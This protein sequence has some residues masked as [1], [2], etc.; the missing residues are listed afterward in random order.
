MEVTLVALDTA[1]PKILAPCSLACPVSDWTLW[2]RL[3]R[4]FAG[5]LGADVVF[6]PGRRLSDKSLVALDEWDGGGGG[7]G[8]W[9][10]KL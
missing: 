10:K 6:E 7:G 2:R 9:K 3:S 5:E 4:D 1:A 8:A